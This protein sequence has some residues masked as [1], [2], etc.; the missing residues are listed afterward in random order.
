MV[1]DV[2]RSL[3]MSM[4]G[5]EILGEKVRGDRPAILT[6]HGSLGPPLLRGREAVL[7]EQPGCPV[8]PIRC[9]SSTR[10]RCI[11]ESTQVPFDWAKA[12]SIRG[13]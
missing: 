6:L 11:R 10:N 13:R 3:A 7:P 1:E 9:P 8:P 5:F 12:E 2:G 4:L